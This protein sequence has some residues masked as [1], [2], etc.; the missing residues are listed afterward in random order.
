MRFRNHGRRGSNVI[1]FA[2]TLPAF[3]LIVCGMMDYGYLFALQ[4]G[5]D[6]AA[7]LGCRE[8]ALIDPL[9]GSPTA[10]ATTY[11]T[12]MGTF[13][14]GSHCTYVTQDLKTGSY[15][16]PNRTLKCEIDRTVTPIVGFVPYPTS[17]SSVAY[18]RFEWQR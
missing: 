8:G 3:L 4:A 5:I 14:C 18:Y 1:E 10:T 15:T 16:V 13:F 17:L 11:M 9:G 7:S 12:S 6:N 2:L